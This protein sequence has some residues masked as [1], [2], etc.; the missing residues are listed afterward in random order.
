M[1][2]LLLLHHVKYY[3]RYPSGYP[4]SMDMDCGR[5]LST[6]ACTFKFTNK[7]DDTYYLLK[8]NTP[9]DGLYSPFVTVSCDGV[10][11]QYE[12]IIVHYAPL[13]KNEFVPLRVGE[14]ISA[15]VQ[16]TDAFTFSSDGIY[17]I[18]YANPLQVI[19]EEQMDLQSV[20][21]IAHKIQVSEAVT[22]NLENTHLL[23]RPEPE[24]SSTNGESETVY[25]ESCSSA[26]LVNGNSG[27]RTNATNAHK[28]L[29][30][31]FGK[32]R[33]AVKNDTMY[34]TWFGTYTTTRSDK[35]KSVL[36]TC[37]DGITG[38]TVTYDMAGP[39]CKSDWNAYVNRND[40]KK[41]VFLCPNWHNGIRDLYC[42]KSDGHAS[43]ESI[44]A[45]EWTHK[46][47][48][49]E[50][51]DTYGA[52]AN[53]EM[54]RNDPDKAVNHADSYEYYYCLAA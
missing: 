19:S 17:T 25:I 49:T 13:S 23:T 18:T 14:S 37:K 26:T 50:D 53:M 36:K 51:Y 30:A 29:C 27:Q 42:R 21:A 52:E 4:I 20:A 1:I 10:P 7:D 40:G 3:C 9:L 12:G 45:H 24:Q 32:A 43:K 5:A 6:V 46:F 38:N 44:L 15:T 16:L 35:V 48:N 8:R 22:I 54:A 31:Q 2:N 11:I 34:V 39:S 41:K 47:A 33:D 28:K